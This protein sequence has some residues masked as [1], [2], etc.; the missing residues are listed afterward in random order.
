MAC[1]DSS[2]YEEINGHKWFDLYEGEMSLWLEKI[3]DTLLCI[4]GNPTLPEILMLWRQDVRS[5]G[6]F[7]TNYTNYSSGYSRGRMSRIIWHLSPASSLLCLAMNIATVRGI[8]FNDDP[9]LQLWWKDHKNEDWSRTRDVE[10]EAVIR[11]E[12]ST[13][14]NL[15]AYLKLRTNMHKKNIYEDECQDDELE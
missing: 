13:N 5:R 8:N 4:E 10:P 1:M 12:A 9:G 7:A 11:E 3:I 2:H 14:A 15:D 6:R